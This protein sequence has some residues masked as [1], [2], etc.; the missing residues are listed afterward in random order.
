MVTSCCRANHPS[1]HRCSLGRNRCLELQ[2]Q[3]VFAMK[4]NVTL[5]GFY[6]CWSNSSLPVHL[7]RRISHSASE[8]A[9]CAMQKCFSNVIE[10]EGRLL[11]AVESLRCL[12]VIQTQTTNKKDLSDASCRNADNT[13]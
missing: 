4:H 6:S 12:A 1:V 8:I 9:Y 3:D 2:H 10:P 7:G 5:Y 13:R 11:R